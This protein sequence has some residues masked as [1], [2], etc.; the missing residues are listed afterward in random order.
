MH[1][2]LQH[3]ASNGFFGPRPIIRLAT[4]TL[5]RTLDAIEP[6]CVFKDITGFSLGVAVIRLEQVG[7]GVALNSPLEPGA[8]ECSP[9]NNWLGVDVA[10]NEINMVLDRVCRDLP[11]GR[12]IPASRDYLDTY[13]AQMARAMDAIIAWCDSNDAWADRDA[14]VQPWKATLEELGSG[15]FTRPGEFTLSGEMRKT[16]DGAW[17]LAAAMP[18]EDERFESLAEAY[19]LLRD[20][21][22]QDAAYEADP[23]ADATEFG[24]PA[25]LSNHADNLASAPPPDARHGY[26]PY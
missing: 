13:V 7:S 21:G 8:V 23:D 15:R 2:V 10:Y 16:L 14:L 3:E 22:W 6:G 19:F 12:S 1:I 18:L 17:A 4:G 11:G 25:R 9:D 5:T 26:S 24:Q 20:V